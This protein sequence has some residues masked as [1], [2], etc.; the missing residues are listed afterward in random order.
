MTGEEEQ[1]DSFRVYFAGASLAFGLPFLIIE[2][3]ALIYGDSE[4]VLSIFSTLFI[5]L[6]LV[7]GLIGGYS[8]ARIAKGDLIRVGT[9]TGVLAYI[10]QQVVYTIFYGGGAVGDALTMVGLIGGSTVGAVI[11]KSR[12]DAYSRIMSR[13]IEEEK[14]KEEEVEAG[15]EGQEPSH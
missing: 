13:R 7:G 11:Y 10:I 3:L 14:E 8:A 2:L 5:V 4:K 9:V 6:H 15:E 1:R 12:A